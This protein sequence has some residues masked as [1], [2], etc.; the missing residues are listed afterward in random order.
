MIREEYSHETKRLTFSLQA[1]YGRVAVVLEFAGLS[2]SG[3][4]CLYIGKEITR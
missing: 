2:R 4:C 1:S 3:A